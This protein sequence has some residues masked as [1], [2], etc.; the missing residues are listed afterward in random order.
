[1]KYPLLLSL[2]VWNF[3]A[4]LKV[5]IVPIISTA[6]LLAISATIFC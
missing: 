6:S 5:G 1:M 3:L 4:V 2:N